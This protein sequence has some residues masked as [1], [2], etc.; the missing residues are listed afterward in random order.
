MFKLGISIYKEGRIYEGGYYK[1]QKEG[2]GCEIYSNGN[3]YVGEYV[4]NKKH[5]KGTFFWFSLSI[6]L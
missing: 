1:N 5:G 3:M 6:Y 2:K 4:Q